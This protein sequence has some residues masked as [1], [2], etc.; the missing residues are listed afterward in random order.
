MFVA[1]VK[2]SQAMC[3]NVCTP[4]IIVYQ[5][6]RDG[7]NIVQTM[8]REVSSR[9]LTGR[10]PVCFVSSSS[11][12]HR[13][14]TT[15]NCAQSDRRALCLTVCSP[16]ETTARR[17]PSTIDMS[18]STSSRFSGASEYFCLSTLV[19]SWKSSFGTTTRSCWICRRLP[20]MLQ[21][22]TTWSKTRVSTAQLCL[23]KD[24]N[25]AACTGIW[26]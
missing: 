17:R 15:P 24:C 9:C 22:S 25:N 16:S 23:L 1:D 26:L 18:A 5:W 19:P 7:W 4:C 12:C 2:C 6:H 10:F 13:R 11:I 14:T 20:P 3:M 8:N 21:C